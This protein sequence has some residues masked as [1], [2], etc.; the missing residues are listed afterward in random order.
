VLNQQYS[1]IIKRYVTKF[2][3]IIKPLQFSDIVDVSVPKNVQQYIINVCDLM[4]VEENIDPPNIQPLTNH[5]EIVA[6]IVESSKYKDYVIKCIG[7]LKTKQLN[8]QFQSQNDV[9]F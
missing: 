3:Q 6:R 4:D 5:P 1:Q 7:E 9:F 8:E 2:E